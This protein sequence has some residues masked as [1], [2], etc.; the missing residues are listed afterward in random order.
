[1][2]L[3]LQDWHNRFLIQAQWT[4]T[5][6][7]YFFELLKTR[8]ADRILDIGCGTGALLPDLGA[9]TAAEIH[10]ADISLEHLRLAQAECPECLLTAGDAHCLP[11]PEDAFDICLAHYFLMW[12]S[13]PKT[14]LKELKRVTK[15]G[16]YLVCF[17]EPDYGGRLDYPPEF[18]SLRDYQI[19]ALLH[20]GADP[21]MG[22]KLKGLFH[23]LEL[24]DVQCGVY[25]GRWD[26]NPSQSELDSEWQ[27]LASDL[28]GI[29]SQ[30]EINQLKKH[31]LKA[32]Q[33][34]SRL[35]YVPTFYAWG[36]VTK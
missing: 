27:T 28:G 32:R 30:S 34:G 10:G 22:R 23:S 29:L 3:S 19:S 25:E 17:A 9:L 5:L 8:P 6:R 26:K 35:V 36:K 18:I 7:L 1:M 11:Y 20:A 31:D 24:G 16:G 12:A 4:K 14:A 2:S 33:A 21:R 13:N 15:N